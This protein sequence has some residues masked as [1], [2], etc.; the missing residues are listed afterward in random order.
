MTLTK[1]QIIEKIETLGG[2][3]TKNYA[4]FKFDTSVSNDN[5]QS[6]TLV[7]AINVETKMMDLGFDGAL[8]GHPFDEDDITYIYFEINTKN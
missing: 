2:A 3:V 8:I 1:N 7:E 4:T 5:C 6:I